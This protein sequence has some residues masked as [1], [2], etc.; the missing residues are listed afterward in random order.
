MKKV[1]FGA[2]AALAM[3]SCSTEEV[4]EVN[5]ANDV[6]SYGVVA[7][8][9]T[10][11]QDVYCN[12]NLPASFVV[13]AEYDSKLYFANE[14]VSYDGAKWN[15][16]NTYYWPDGEL[17]FYAHVNAGAAFNYTAGTA[18]TINDFTVADAV[19]SQV[20]LLYAAKAQA[21]SAGDQV[22]LNF[23]HALSQVVFQAK[24]A[25]ENLYVEI[26]GVTVGNVANKNTFTYPATT[27]NNL[28]DHT[29]NV[30]INYTDGSW[31]EW[32][33]ITKGTG[34]TDYAVEFPAVPLAVKDEVYSLTNVTD[35][36][37]NHETVTPANA[38]LLLPQETDAWDPETLGA[39]EDANKNSYL[40]VK[41]AIYNIAGATFDSA[42]DVPL[43]GTQAAHQEVAI[44]IAFNW[45]Q[46]KKY[47]Y[48]LVFGETGGIG[49]G[50]Y[51]PDPDPDPVLVPISFTVTVDDFKLVDAGEHSVKF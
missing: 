8:N 47:V 33:A 11:A 2:L 19:G 50:G 6:I 40:L 36:E 5:R 22:K 45:E 21:K 7:N 37:T 26:S 16:T 32:A 44:P 34:T 25:N 43:W 17:Q 35:N 18:P 23:R 28:V 13:A 10:R 48:T 46:G 15:S 1:L 29:G 38:M 14:T 24:N 42:T 27:D 4:L 39:K 3:V 49:G 12:V 31:G 41:C 30:T 9:S 20:D 51:E